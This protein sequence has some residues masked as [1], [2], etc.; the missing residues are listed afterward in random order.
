[1]GPEKSCYLLEEIRHI[2]HPYVGLK[3]NLLTCMKDSFLLLSD[4]GKE[5]VLLFHQELGG[6]SISSADVCIT[7]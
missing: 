2:N 5:G 4:E 7:G 6:E 1:M 3:Q